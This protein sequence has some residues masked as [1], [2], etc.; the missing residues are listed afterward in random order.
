MTTRRA[1]G[2]GAAGDSA[3]TGRG[4][5]DTALHQVVVIT[6][7]LEG[8]LSRAGARNAARRVEA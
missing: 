6:E 1:R 8:G 5:Q 2:E 7:I 4:A 3:D